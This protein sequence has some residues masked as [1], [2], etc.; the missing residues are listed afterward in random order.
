MST[1]GWTWQEVE[2]GLE[3]VFIHLMGRRRGA[4][5]KAPTVNTWFSW[6]R[7]LGIVAKE[8]IQMRRDRLTFGMMVGI[9]MIQ[10]TLFGYAINSDPKHL[11][12]ALLI[13]EQ[14]EFARS[15][16]SSMRNS[17]YFEF[18]G[19]AADEADARRML[20]TGRRAVRRDHSA[21]FSRRLLRGEHPALLVEADADRSGRTG[22][23]IS[24][25][26]RCAHQR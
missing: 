12:T 25:L 20:A 6:S 8:F 5:C 10:L 26:N 18:V 9:P 13:A 1:P 3:D 22:N 14:S 23:A 24:A 11:P 19:E 21:D 15:I 17:D 16:L 7:W 4:R 2:P